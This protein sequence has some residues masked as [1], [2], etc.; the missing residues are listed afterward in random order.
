MAVDQRGGTVAKNARKDIESQIGESV[1]SP[2]NAKAKNAL[3]I[4][5]IEE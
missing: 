4:K 2:L 3:E 5:R 1:I